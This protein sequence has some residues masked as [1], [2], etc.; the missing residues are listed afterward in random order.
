MFFF[1]RPNP[2]TLIGSIVGGPDT[3]ER[4]KD[5]RNEYHYTEVALDYNAAL[6]A[7]L[8]GGA[9][10]PPAV[11]AT[12]CSA[13]IPKF[14]FGPYPAKDSKARQSAY[15][16]GDNPNKGLDVGPTLLA[17]AAAARA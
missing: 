5:E 11:W 2:I 12:D 7:A 9:S 16:R 1:D 10:M 3:Q 4:F 8:A 6:M 17:A 15:V 14:T 13:V